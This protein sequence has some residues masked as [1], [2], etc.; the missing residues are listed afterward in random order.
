ME[1]ALLALGGPTNIEK[2]V[3]VMQRR[4]YR[5]NG[6]VSAL[7]LPAM[8]PLCFV[9]PQMIPGTRVK[10]RE[11]LRS[12][13]GREAPYLRSKSL[14]DSDGFLFWDLAPRGELQR[15]KQSCERGFAPRE[16]AQPTVED[17]ARSDIF[18]VARGFF[19]CSMEGCNRGEITAPEVPDPLVFP[20]KSAYLLYLR[21]LAVETQAKQNA[22]SVENRPWWKTLLWEKVE[23]IPLR[24]ST[25]AG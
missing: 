7:A 6:L 25:A 21:T 9:A 16:P 12:A 14:A 2:K 18:P 13:V 15:L 4:L 5:Q 11:A 19:L 22:S 8:I 1:F 10:L 24:K 20:A 17:A 23:E 3:R